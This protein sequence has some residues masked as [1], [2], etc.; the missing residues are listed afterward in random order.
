MVALAGLLFAACN[1]E[2]E[3]MSEQ[4]VSGAKELSLSAAMADFT[5]ATDTAF[6]TGDQIGFFAI[7]PDDTYMYDFYYFNA[8]LVV[9]E[10]GSLN[11]AEDLNGDGVTDANDRLVW[12]SDESSVAEL[13][14]YYPYN[15]EHDSYRLVHFR[16]E[17]DQTS[18]AAYT[19]SDHMMAYLE[20]SP[21]EETLTLP[22]R[23][24]LSKVVVTVNNE[25]GEEIRD[26]WFADVYGEGTYR[27]GGS[28]ES[29]SGEKGI[30]RAYREPTRAE[31]TFRLI[32]APQADAEPRLIVTTA[33]G[34]Q[35]AFDLKKSVTFASGKQYTATITLN[36]ESTSTD[37]SPEISEWEEDKQFVFQPRESLWSVIGSFNDWN[38]DV[39]M[40]EVSRNYYVVEME[41][42]GITQ[43]KVRYDRSWA[44]NRGMVEEDI[45]T[46]Y[47]FNWPFEAIQDGLNII[48]EYTGRC[49]VCYDANNEQ[50][51]IVAL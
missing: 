9:G 38:D 26:L 6:E 14:A 41:F 15:A 22:F 5:R 36:S 32:L 13:A 23:H 48:L 42:E 44:T 39:M 43:F 12:H 40:T 51:S 20:S 21:T 50:I 34:K 31:E 46:R 29:T 10:D 19:A 49:Q 45:L 18:W 35:Y 4:S 1:T 27:L 8:H 47:D 7:L 25:L 37:F 30:I 24:M 3:L 2:E 11:V 33:S 16:V 28:V 17:P